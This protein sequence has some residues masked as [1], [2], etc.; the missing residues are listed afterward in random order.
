M[1]INSARFIGQRKGAKEKG[2]QPFPCPIEHVLDDSA[3]R[4]ACDFGHG[5]IIPDG[6]QKKW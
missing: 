2:N 4:D 1:E 6:G 5:G 3:G